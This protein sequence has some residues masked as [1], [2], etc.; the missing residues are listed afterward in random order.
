VEFYPVNAKLGKQFE[1]ADKKAMKYAVLF[2]ESE[3]NWWYFI[4]KDL[5]T[6][7]QISEIITIS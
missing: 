6:W 4:V 7:E 5:V 2:W 1:Y 3:K